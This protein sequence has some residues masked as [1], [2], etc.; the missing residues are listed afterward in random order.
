MLKISLPVVRTSPYSVHKL[1]Q[2]PLL[3][4]SL[5]FICLLLLI[6]QRLCVSFF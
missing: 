2:L 6:A 5:N 1:F 4:C 3:H